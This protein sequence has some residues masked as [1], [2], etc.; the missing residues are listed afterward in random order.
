MNLEKIQSEIRKQNIDG[1]LFYDFHNRD[2]MAYRILGLEWNKFTSRRWYY[3]IPA[4]GQPV[5]LVSSVEATKLD[6]LPGEKMV[7]RSYEQQHA[8]IR[9]ML[10][11]S[12]RIAMQ[13]SP[14]NNIPYV[15]IVDAG[16][17]ELLRSF[18]VE[19]VTSANLV[20]TFEAIIDEEGYR[21]HLQAG[22]KVQRI[23]DEAFALIDRT[24]R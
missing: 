11:K 2:A 14:I 3:F 6:T 8:S 21:L 20:Q 16:T 1:W 4:E 12:R 22:E 19:I 13:Y 24:I 17:I 15:S 10:G 7:Y 18:G 9:Q 23:K 5:R